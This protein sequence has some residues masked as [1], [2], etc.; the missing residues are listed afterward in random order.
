MAVDTLT[1]L[2]AAVT[3][4]LVISDQPALDSRLARAGLQVESRMAEPARGGMN[5]ALAHGAE[6][7]TRGYRTVLA[8]VGE[9]PALRPESVEQ[10]VGA[11]TGL[12]ARFS[13][14]RPEWGRR[15]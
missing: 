7:R 15:C 8:C 2:S 14:T 9:L 5:A 12:G 1:A 6:L 11:A 13:P 10:I 3:E 4:V